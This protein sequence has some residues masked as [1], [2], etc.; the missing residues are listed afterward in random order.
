MIVTQH[1]SCHGHPPD[2]LTRR[3][4]LDFVVPEWHLCLHHMPEEHQAAVKRG[5][6]SLLAHTCI[7]VGLRQPH[8]WSALLLTWIVRLLLVFRTF[9]SASWKAFCSLCSIVWA[10][11]QDCM[12]SDWLTNCSTGRRGM[13]ALTTVPWPGSLALTGVTIWNNT[14][15][16]KRNQANKD[17]QVWL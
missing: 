7:A 15:L 9:L 14:I 2:I 4:W 6:K 12:L 3:D 11:L 17:R 1:P 10:N 5:T 16:G 8:G 13:T